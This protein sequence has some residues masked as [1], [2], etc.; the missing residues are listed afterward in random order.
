MEFSSDT[1]LLSTKLK[2]PAPRKNYVVRR[3]L[4]E[5]LSS[6]ADMSVIFVRGGAGM[7]KTTLLSSFILEKTLKN[8]CW[9]SIDGSNANVYSFWLYFTAAV[10]ALREDGGDLLA[11][12]RS[13]PD[14]SH[15][16]QQLIL[17]I[18]WLCVDEDYFMVLDDVHNICD[19]ALIKSLE[20]FL[21]SMPSNF[22]LFMLS[23][24]DPPVYLGPLA[25]SGR[26]MFIDGN[27]MRLTPEEG[28]SFLKNTLGIKCG[29]EELDRLNT[30]AE[31][32]IGGLQLA[33]AAG[34]ADKNPDRLIRSGG[35]IAAEYLTRE[36]LET[37]TQTE[38]DFLMK[39]GF[40]AYFNAEIVDAV[41]DGCSR[42]AF[43]G[44]IE[45]L[46]QK[47]LFIICLDENSGIYRYH[48]ILSEYLTRQLTRLPEDCQKELHLKAARAF[49]LSSDSDEALREYLSAG[50]FDDI[51]RVAEAMGG[52]MEAWS[53]IDKVPIDKLVTNFDLATQCFIYNIGILNVERCKLVY[54]KLKERCGETD[55]FTIM[56][57]AE[58]YISGTEG[59]LPKYNAVTAEQIELLHL[60]PA[61]KA[62]ALVQNAAAFVEQLKYEE[63]EDCISK[64]ITISSDVNAFVEFF[65]YNQLAQIY[66]EIGQL[67]DSLETYKR[68]DRLMSSPSM[69]ASAGT[70]YCF[71]ITGVYMRRME[72]EKAA[73][74]LEQAEHLMKNKHILVDITDLTLAYHKAEMMFLSGDDRAG[75]ASV[76]DLISDYPNFSVLT[77][78]RLVHELDCAGLLRPEISDTF[79]KE[80]DETEEYKAQPFMKLLGARLKFKRGEKK[81]ALKETEEVLVFSRMYKNKLRLVEAGLLKIYMLL[82]LPEKSEGKRE[83]FNLLREAINYAH[84]DRLI[85]PFYLDRAF[86]L[87]LIKELLAQSAGNSFFSTQ[88]AAFVRSVISV[89]SDPGA[90]SKGQELLS[91]R[92]IE[93][94]N[95][96]A[97]GITNREIADKLCISQATVK[98][99]VLSIFGKLGVSSRMA[100]VDIGREEGFIK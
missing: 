79:L 95:E 83:I 41:L 11:M 63:A 90:A 36:V 14:L 99:H 97:L 39:T 4:F 12:I 49:E 48:N 98:T 59:K 67:N 33:A 17:L 13:N 46:E 8:V 65:A 31:G 9:L 30:Y 50:A 15:I 5:K 82:N 53:Y 21:S 66:E 44:M 7:G 23:R 1:L 71:G 91:A 22:H 76:E 56:Q 69:V 87:P 60:G 51:L 86:L 19:A 58:P 25:V 75:A 16:E 64:A 52:R 29:S 42:A 100:A 78:G 34:A 28:L 96:L 93:V 54:E 40:L 26:F 73:E 10:S 89:C 74:V 27:Q 55:A 62:M 35:G 72:L 92:E 24:E 61:I 68:S 20:F 85:M 6:C 70:N 88:E 2:I 77:M 45:A 37:L 32:W 80:L 43:D 38:R 94:L 57:F 81:E 18:N 84:E 47:N 3:A